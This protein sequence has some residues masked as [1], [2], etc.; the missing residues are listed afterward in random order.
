MCVY[1]SS[2]SWKGVC[3]CL[4]EVLVDQRTA[5][6]DMLQQLLKQRD[7]REQELQQILVRKQSIIFVLGTNT[8]K[9]GLNCK[10]YI[11]LTFYRNC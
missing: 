3:V 11:L 4:Q 7:Q 6:S 1:G 8:P 2:A 9:T 10:T 5:L